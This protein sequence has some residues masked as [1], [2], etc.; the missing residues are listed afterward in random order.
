MTVFQA[1]LPAPMATEM[2]LMTGSVEMAQLDDQIVQ[3]D[4]E[5]RDRKQRAL[6]MRRRL[7]QQ[8]RL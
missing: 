6:D 8:I 4:G 3:L 5:L 1:S 2:A 7:D